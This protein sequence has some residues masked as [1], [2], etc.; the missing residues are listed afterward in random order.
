M[1]HLTSEELRVRLRTPRIP[2][3][4][5]LL[6]RLIEVHGAGGRSD[7]EAATVARTVEKIRRHRSLCVIRIIG[8]RNVPRSRPESA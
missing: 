4:D 7:I 8:D 6:E 2:D 1:G 3:K 5:P